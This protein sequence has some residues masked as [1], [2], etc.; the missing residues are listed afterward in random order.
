MQKSEAAAAD[1]E[2]GGPVV[3]RPE[4]EATVCCWKDRPWLT[5]AQVQTDPA[6]SGRTISLSLGT[7]LGPRKIIC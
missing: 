3:R 2:E 7:G 5:S 4:R 6:P 1:G